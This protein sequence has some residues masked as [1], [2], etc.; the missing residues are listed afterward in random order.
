MALNILKGFDICFAGVLADN[1]RLV[2]IEKV[3]I[4]FNSLMKAHRKEVSAI[5]TT[6]E[7]LESAQL[8]S[9]KDSL[10]NF[11]K[12]DEKVLVDTAVNPAILGG[13]TV[14]VGDKFVDLSIIKRINEIKRLLDQ[15]LN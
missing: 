2:E 12:T 14:R 9:V 11:V 3:L 7:P 6:A 10:K 15:P 8:A 13:L 5:V 4:G 1:G